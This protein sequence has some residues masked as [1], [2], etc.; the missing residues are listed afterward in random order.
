MEG[1]RSQSKSRRWV[2]RVLKFFM[3]RLGGLRGMWLGSGAPLP[4][5]GVSGRSYAGGLPSI[6]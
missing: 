5:E 2:N 6:S 4:N 1:V 3:Y